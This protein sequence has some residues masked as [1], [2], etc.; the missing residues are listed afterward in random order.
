MLDL[1]R[2]APSWSENSG[3]PSLKFEP[4]R[5]PVIVSAND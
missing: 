1:F 5:N 3:K 4:D 2:P